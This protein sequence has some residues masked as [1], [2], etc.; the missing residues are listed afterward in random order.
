MSKQLVQRFKDKLDKAS[1]RGTMRRFLR[2]LPGL[3]VE[4]D[5]PP[6]PSSELVHVDVPVGRV[7][8]S[9]EGFEGEAG[10]VLGTSKTYISLE[11]IFV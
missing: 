4:V 9:S 3:G 5:I 2:E 10:S 8:Q 7:V 6:E 1:L 11:R